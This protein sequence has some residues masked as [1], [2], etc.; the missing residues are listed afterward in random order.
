MFQWNTHPEHSECCK[1]TKN[2]TGKSNTF[3]RASS[4]GI[5]KGIYL[6]TSSDDITVVGQSG[7][8]NTIDTFLAVP[9]KKLCLSEYV[10]YPFSIAAYVHADASFAIVGTEDETTITIRVSVNSKI[11]F[12]ST[13]DWKKLRSGKKRSYVINRLQTVYV[14]AYLIDL[15]GSKVIADKPLSIIS[16][17]E[18]A[19][20][21]YNI[22]ACD[23]L[24]E[25]VLP[26]ALWGTTYFIAPL[27]I[28]KSYTLKIVAA[29]DETKVQIVC[30]GN[31]TNLVIDDGEHVEQVY[32]NQ[33]YCAV[34][35]NKKISVVQLSHGTGEDNVGD[36]MMTLVPEVN[37][38]SNKI[39]SSTSHD[40]TFTSHSQFLN[41]IVMPEYYQPQLITVNAGSMN[42]T[43][44]S[45]NWVPITVNNTIEA[46]ASQIYL[47]FSEG[48]FQVTHFNNSAL[49]SAIHYGF[50]IN[51][52]DGANSRAGYGHP[53][54]LNNIKKYLGKFAAVEIISYLPW[55]Y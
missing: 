34:Y 37:D 19:F 31:E 17:H 28:R 43:L 47:N 18:C 48:I 35:S 50:L 33:E 3:P 13:T 11:S 45:Y 32:R 51:E 6:K 40:A 4:D 25:Q 27:A 44:E 12:N 20:V 41:I 36:P 10:Y 8:H 14:S 39:F 7:G 22:G 52:D 49:M 15:T 38:Y 54:G 30:N 55:V 29:N 23:H 24:V 42:E 9:T 2:L 26:T 1:F 21:P 53:A 46:Y 16:G 5:T